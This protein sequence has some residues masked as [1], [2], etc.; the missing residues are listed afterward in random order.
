MSTFI[1][2]YNPASGS[3]RALAEALGIRR[4]KHNT[5]RYRRPQRDLII[6]W[7]ASEFQPNLTGQEVW[8]HANRTAI[9]TNKLEFFRTLEGS[10]YVRTVPFTTDR[11]VASTWEKCVARTLLRGSE[12]RGIIVSESSTPPVQA[13]LYTKYIPKQREFRVH[14]A[15]GSVV[16]SQRKIADPNNPPTNFDLRNHDNGFLFARNSGTPTGDSCRMAIDTL[17]LL[18]LDFGAV[19]LIEN[20]KGTWILEVNTAPGLEG[21]TLETY[22]N[23]FEQKIRDRR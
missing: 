20:K 15:F 23:A 19:D 5:D 8:N 9:A 1:Y 12:G 3:A 7:G 17:R 14:V 16:D 2:P 21:Q 18:G 13:P 22:R 10:E 6:N 4:L 11:Q